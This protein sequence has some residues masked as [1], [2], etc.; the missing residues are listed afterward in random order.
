MM[1]LALLVALA[2]AMSACSTLG[3]GGSASP[4]A[5]PAP[6]ATP[7]PTA[8]VLQAACNTGDSAA[9]LAY[10][11]S[12]VACGTAMSPEVIAAC[13]IGGYPSPVATAA[14]PTLGK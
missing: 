11:A 4:T 2:I 8:K 10:Q 9:C 13:I 1:K 14:V 3:L 5:I 12:L 6:A 7:L